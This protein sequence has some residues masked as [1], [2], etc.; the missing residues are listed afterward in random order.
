MQA[1]SQQLIIQVVTRDC[2]YLILTRSN[3]AHHCDTFIFYIYL[4]LSTVRT[5]IRVYHI[6]RSQNVRLLTNFNVDVNGIPFNLIF[7]CIAWKKPLKFRTTL[8]WGW[9]WR[10]KLAATNVINHCCV[11]LNTYI[12]Y[13]YYCISN[14]RGC[15]LPKQRKSILICTRCYTWT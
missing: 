4:Q 3:T 2:F 1:L 5:S 10:P 9:S 15:P 11:R 12:F 14:T 6:I 8:A 7:L 13:F